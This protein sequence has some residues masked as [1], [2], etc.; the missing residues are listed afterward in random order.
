[1]DFM[2]RDIDYVIAVAE[3]RSISK[4]AELLYISQPSLSRYLSRLESELGVSLFIRNSNG[5][6]LTEAGQIYVGYAKEIR[7]LKGT[8]KIKLRDLKRIQAGR[9]RIGMPLNAISLSAFNVAEEITKRY[10]ECNVDMFNILSKDIPEMLK[11]R[12]YD[13]VIGPDLNWPQEFVVK[14]LYKEPYILVVPEK[15]QQGICG[16]IKENLPFPLVDLRELPPVDF[17]LQDDT[18]AV[19]KNIDRICQNI[20][21]HV[22]PKMLVSNTVV[23]LQA[24]ENQVGCCIVTLG[25]LAYLNHWNK[26]KFYVISDREYSCTAVI[27]LRGR[28]PL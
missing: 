5:T 8:L 27:Y 14:F 12:T 26:L 20:G 17:I 19:R 21:F 7:R 10:P 2:D 28:L 18:T 15:Y 22:R 13:F 3:C 16:T 6:E 9:I 11:N 4:A 1:M 24:A 23:A 25:Q